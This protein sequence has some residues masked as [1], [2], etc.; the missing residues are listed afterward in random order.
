MSY[1]DGMTRLR[2]N[3]ALR[4][5]DETRTMISIELDM[6]HIMSPAITLVP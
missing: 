1:T 5:Y 2:Y 6:N 3:V 4:A